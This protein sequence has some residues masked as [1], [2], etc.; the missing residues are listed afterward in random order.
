MQPRRVGPVVIRRRLGAE[1]RRLREEANMR[2]DAVAKA[3]E[4]S[5]SKISRLETGHGI[6]R[7]WDVR[8]LLTLYQVEDERLRNRL[9]GW[10]NDGRATAW[11][12]P[13]SDATP[14]D[15][16]YYISLEAEAS[17]MLSYCTPTL[18]GLLTGSS[19]A[20]SGAS[21]PCSRVVGWQ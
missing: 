16:D 2:L 15:L 14:G 4:M 11:W 3:L 19:H 9:V 7:S 1:L 5:A 8:N 6:P 17:V 13:Y 18:H 21:P 12:Q 10:A 20:S